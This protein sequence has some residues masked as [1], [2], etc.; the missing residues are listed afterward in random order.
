MLLIVSLMS[1]G[2]KSN[3]N[4]KPNDDTPREQPNDDTSRSYSGVHQS[5]PIPQV[6]TD[7]ANNLFY[8]YP[9]RKD[10]FIDDTNKAKMENSKIPAHKK[11]DKILRVVSYNVHF[12]TKTKE[13][14]TGYTDDAIEPILNVIRTLNADVLCLQEVSYGNHLGGGAYLSD[15][16][17][18]KTFDQLK[19]DFK[20]MGYLVDDAA[21]YQGAQHQSSPFGNLVLSKYPLAALGK[22][23]RD[24]STPAIRGEK[25]GFARLHVELPRGEKLVVLSTHLEVDDTLAGTRR[26]QLRDVQNYT[27]SLV[28]E[29]N[30]IVAG[31][32][33][34]VR[35]DE[36]SYDVNGQTA[37]H[38]FASKQQNP[39][40]WN[41]ID[42]LTGDG[43]VDSFSKK[44]WTKPKYTTWNGSTI[45]YVF[46]KDTLKFEV[47]GSYVYFDSS[48]DY[49]PVV[50]DLVLTK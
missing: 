33:N 31:D 41:V 44:S 40:D 2:K 9:Q 7:I 49:L 38:W 6:I 21:F 15:K 30:V 10:R 12:W 19:Q 35:K 16:V 34:Q 20:A 24:F 25:R 5:M 23:R 18:K 45:D 39:I 50:V 11:N 17:K 42:V 36:L 27:N 43:Y 37:W 46:L 4:E 14:L 29:P 3:P 13:P 22:G 8:S 48:S 28:D 32:M 1:C 26:A 47:A